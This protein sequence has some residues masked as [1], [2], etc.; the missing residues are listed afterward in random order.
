MLLLIDAG[1]TRIKWAVAD[2]NGAAP[3]IW[4]AEGAVP[5]AAMNQLT[6]AWR[7]ALAGKTIC[8]VLV[9]NVAGPVMRERLQQA[10]PAGLDAHA[11]RWFAALPELAG[12]RN[13][14]RDPARLGAD[15][16]AS[17]IGAHALQPGQ[18]L[19][20][21]TCGTATT[22][23]ALTC[24]GVFLGGMILPGPT[25]MASSLAHN[26]F[27]L[28][29]IG[30]GAALPTGIADNTFDAIL[31]GCLNAQAGAIERAYAAHRATLCILS[32]GAAQAIAPMLALPQLV[33]DNLV[34]IGLHAVLLLDRS[35]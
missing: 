5:H 7:Q 21:A 19:I 4:L 28:P 8:R 18:D 22:V 15:R 31:A 10:L 14:Y 11:V 12:V 2:D 17:A 26:T 29:Q 20:I 6:H 34:L 32:G 33:V 24:D 35:C 23:D 25:L 3:G 16:F 13:A 27:Q 1:N 9:S 30:P